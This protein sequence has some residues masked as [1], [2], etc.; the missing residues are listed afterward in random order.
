M[1]VQ[2][3]IWQAQDLRPAVERTVP[4]LLEPGAVWAG[5]DAPV[6]LLLHVG[7]R[8]H[9]IDLRV[10]TG[11]QPGGLTVPTAMANRMRRWAKAKRAVLHTVAIDER[12]LL[13]RSGH[14]FYYRRGVQPRLRLDQ[15]VRVTDRQHLLQ[16]LAM[17]AREIGRLQA[18]LERD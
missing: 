11:D 15:M 4:T 9:G 17:T 12:R 6:D 3:F 5:P 1:S 13:A 16:L 7:N 10:L 18:E 2:R 14:P 8:L